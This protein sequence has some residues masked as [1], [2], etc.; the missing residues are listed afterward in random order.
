MNDQTNKQ[1]IVAGAKPQAIVPTDFDGAWRIATMVH[2]SGMLPYGIDTAAKAMAAIMHGM[3][4]GLTPMNALQSIAVINGRPTI[5]GDAALGLVRASGLLEKFEE[6][7]TGTPFSDDYTAICT[8]R[9]KGDPSDV[10]GEFSVQDAKL[11]HLWDKRGK[12]G[13]ETPWQTYP[14]RMLKMRARAFALRDAFTDILKGL[15]IKEEMEDVER[16]QVI[17]H[18][19]PPIPPVTVEAKLVIVDEAKGETL[20]PAEM[21]EADKVVTTDGKVLK[22]RDGIADA[23]QEPEEELPPEPPAEGAAAEAAPTGQS[24]A[25]A[26]PENAMV[27]MPDPET[28]ITGWLEWLDMA[29][30]LCTQASF[31]DFWERSVQPIVDG[32]PEDLATE[33]MAVYRKHE[34][35]VA[36]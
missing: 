23:A 16:A 11:A 26:S 6:T 25:A 22:D 24:E 14:K 9:R 5:W 3:E 4:L 10:V 35:R 30:G 20:G 7:S 27:V 15:G 21:A 17:E 1:L 18:D 2:Q 28:D 13:Q 29:L 12:N 8:V 36:P 31:A 34:Q 19:A 33:A 32:M